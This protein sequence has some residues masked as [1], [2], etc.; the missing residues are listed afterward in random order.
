MLPKTYSFLSSPWKPAAALLML[1]LA[2]SGCFYDNEVD[3]YP[4]TLGCDSLD[5]SFSEIIFPMIQANC[6][7]VG[8]HVSGGTGNGIFEN[9]DQIK[10]KVDNGSMENRVVVLRDMPPGNSL[11]DCQISQ[12]QSWLDAGAPNN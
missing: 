9:Y 4:D 7:T 1:C 5:V 6:N 12:V 8:C 11:T 3:L 2:V 10:V